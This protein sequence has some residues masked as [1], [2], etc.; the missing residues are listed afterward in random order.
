MQRACDGVDYVLHQ[1]GLSSVPHTIENPIATNE[2]NLVGYL[3]M[4]C[5]GKRAARVKRLCL[6]HIQFYV[7]G[8]HPEL[9]Q[10]GRKDG[11]PLSPYAATKKM[12]E[13]YADF[14]LGYMDSIKRCLRYFNVFGR[15]P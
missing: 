2:H 10:N 14:L 11:H 12:N 15:T 8:D 5:S 6:R 7:Y 1:A 3:N 13:V 4:I 9:P